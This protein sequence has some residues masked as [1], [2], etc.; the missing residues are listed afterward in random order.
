MRQ[1]V[2]DGMSVLL[3]PGPLVV[4]LGLTKNEAGLNARAMRSQ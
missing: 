4:S 3:F 1:P 2:T